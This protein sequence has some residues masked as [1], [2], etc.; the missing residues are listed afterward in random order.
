MF[1]YRENPEDDNWWELL[2][3]TIVMIIIFILLYLF[4]R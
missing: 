4:A 2:T 3:I 1:W